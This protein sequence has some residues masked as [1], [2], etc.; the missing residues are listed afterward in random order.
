M[1][2]APL[3][4][5]T[6]AAVATVLPAQRAASR[7]GRS[8]ARTAP[9]P[10]RHVGPAGNGR[11]AAGCRATST[12]EERSAASRLSV[13]SRPCPSASSPLDGSSSTKSSPAVRGGPEQPG[14]AGH[15]PATARGAADPQRLPAPPGR[16]VRPPAPMPARE[17]SPP[18]APTSPASAEPSRAAERR[19]VPWRNPR[20]PDDGWPARSAA[21]PRPPQAA[22]SSR[23]HSPL[24]R[25]PHLPAR[26]TIPPAGRPAPGGQPSASPRARPAQGITIIHHHTI[27]DR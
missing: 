23:S 18:S 6:P 16:A 26:P 19:P 21:A 2:S 24:R 11:G 1:S 10:M 3:P 27:I 8:T 4:L 9:C 17:T 7:R 25:P 22:C 5:S 12:T 15:Y 13:L 20:S 14:P